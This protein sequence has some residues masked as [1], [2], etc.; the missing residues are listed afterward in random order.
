VPFALSSS[1]WSVRNESGLVR[2]AVGMDGTSEQFYRV[3]VYNHL[4]L[5]S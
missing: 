5:L 4:E 2:V 1:S 3:I